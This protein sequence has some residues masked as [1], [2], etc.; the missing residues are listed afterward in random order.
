MPLVIGL[1]YRDEAL[2]DS[3]S[4]IE[5]V[6]NGIDASEYCGQNNRLKELKEAGYKIVLFV[7]N[8]LQK[9]PDYFIKV[10]KRVLEFNPKVYF[11]VAGSGDMEQQTIKEATA[12]GI[13]DRVIF[14]GFLRGQELN[15][16]YASADLYVLPSISEPFG[17]T[18]LESLV[19]GTPVLVS[20]Q[21]GVAEVLKH[22]LK[23]DFWDIDD[24]TDKILS[25]INHAPLQRTLAINGEAEARRTTWFECAQKCLNVYNQ[26]IRV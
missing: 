23:S 12:L 22:A 9:G 4:K 15:D 16:L 3:E 6:H 1:K 7:A 19:N 11:V 18:P 13:A 5:V 26:V 17:L 25:V 14:C 21:S 24:M 10:A 2:R 20:K 8:P